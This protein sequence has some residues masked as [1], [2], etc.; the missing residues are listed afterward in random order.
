MR[1]IYKI[2]GGLVG[3]VLLGYFVH[4]LFS[5]FEPASLA[6]LAAPRPIAAIAAAA[7]LYGL[8]I[9]LSARAWRCLL[10][11]S[12]GQWPLRTLCGIMGV[13][14]LAKYVPGNVMQHASRTALTLAHGM[15]LRNFM[16]SVTAE[17]VLALLAALMVGLVCLAGFDSAVSELPRVGAYA[18]FLVLALSIFVL[19]MPAL[20]RMVGVIARKTRWESVIAYWLQSVPGQRAQLRAFAIY[21]GNYLLI[22][23]GFVL[24]VHALGLAHQLGYAQLTAAFALSW[25]AGFLAPGMPAGFGVREGVMALMLGGSA[26]QGDVLSA[27]LAMRLATIC[28]DVAWFIL[29]GWLLANGKSGIKR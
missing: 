8:I 24:I 29:G 19:A 16:T 13:T 20:I 7:A 5:A 17:T 2:I 25:L 15:C 27:I 26:E 9:P 4:F 14:Q 22:G 18:P 21:C 3:L 10:P 11:G 1:S 6:R 12:S 23:G 28:G